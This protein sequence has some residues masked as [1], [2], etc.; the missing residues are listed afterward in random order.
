MP[1]GDRA[2]VPLS[3]ADVSL[4]E[5]LERLIDERDRRLVGVIDERNAHYDTRFKAAETAVAAALAAQ[6][7]ATA[8]NF[9]ANEKAIVKAEDAQREYNIRSNE[10][11]GQLD[12]QAKTLMPRNEAD[13]R[14][15]AMAEKID[16]LQVSMDEK[17]IALRNDAT[18][19]YEANRREIGSLR[20]SRSEGTGKAT[21]ATTSAATNQWVVGIVIGLIFGVPGLLLGLYALSQLAGR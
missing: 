12:D 2:P 16:T 3:S 21:Q 19:N 13:T 14:F 17:L 7:K 8:S 18:A 1:P 15:T 5:Y 9:A 10:F 4:K 11:R 20:E 6:E